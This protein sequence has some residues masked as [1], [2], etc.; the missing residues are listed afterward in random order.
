MMKSRQCSG[1]ALACVWAILDCRR[2]RSARARRA[3]CVRRS[4]HRAARTREPRG[5]GAPKP[6]EM[7]ASF[8]GIT[9][10][11]AYASL[12]P[13]RTCA[14][15]R[16]RGVR[17]GDGIA[18]H[19]CDGPRAVMCGG[20]LEV[21]LDCSATGRVC[22]VSASGIAGCKFANAPS[23]VNPPVGQAS[24][25]CVGSVLHGCC[26][27]EGVAPENRKPKCVPGYET[28]FDCSTIPSASACRSTPLSAYCGP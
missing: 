5:E 21:E 11:E 24:N 26:S 7:Y 17:R 15:V 13:S 10:E 8:G 1:S 22:G 16:D 27:A 4:R 2:S 19:R 20:G 9:E 14:P 25:T 6:S 23:C 12:A 3:S 28:A 18:S